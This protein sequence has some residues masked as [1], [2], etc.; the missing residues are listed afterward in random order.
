MEVKSQPKPKPVLYDV[1]SLPKLVDFLEGLNM[2]NHLQNVVRLGATETQH[3]FRL[4][5]MDYRI[6][7]MEWD[8]SEDD[9]KRL[10]EACETLAHKSI[11]VEKTLDP[12]FEERKGLRYGRLYI[13]N[14]VQSFEY[15]TASM[16]GYPPMSA[17]EMVLSEAPHYGCTVPENNLDLTNKIYVI[18]RGECTFLVKAKIANAL[19][20]SI[21]IIV[22]SEDQ[23][24]SPSSG[25]GVDPAVKLEH[26]EALERMAIIS[27]ANTTWAKLELAA[28]TSPS[29]YAQVV[30]LKCAPG[31]KCFPLMEEEKSLQSEVSSGTLR[32]RTSG[33]EGQS[34]DFLTSTFGSRLP[35]S[36]FRVHLGDPIDG[37]D[38]LTALA[39]NNAEMEVDAEGTGVSKNT[40]PLNTSPQ[41]AAVLLHRGQCRFDLKALHAQAVGAQLQIVVDVEDNALQRLGGMMPESGYVGIPGLLVTALCGSYITAAIQSGQTVTAEIVPAVDAQHAERW[42]ELAYTEWADDDEERLMQLAGLSQK[43]SQL[44]ASEIVQW[45]QRQTDKIRLSHRTE[46]AASIGL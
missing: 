29:A 20:A 26:V 23:L 13:P 34:F 14:A 16:G 44:Q 27:V 5:D 2:S 41:A 28:L 15:V 18:Q 6:M 33:G 39:M 10:R 45:L 40:S 35:L 8:I 31:G 30:P 22:N 1:D 32:V 17:Q 19:N 11:V 46:L 38:N 3:L 43:Y 37:C 12:A 36:E 7:L 21:L 9:V 24:E 42:I 4:S 25:L